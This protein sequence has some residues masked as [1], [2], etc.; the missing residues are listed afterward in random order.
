M[1]TQTW[2]VET[3]AA[4]RYEAL[5]VP[6]LMTAWAPRVV[7]AAGVGTGDRV[8]DVA[9]GTGIVART[10][11]DRVGATGRVVGLD[12][13]PGM[14]AVAARV[15]PDLDWRQG[16]AAALPFPAA[17]F[18][19]VLCQF[20]LMFFPDRLAALREMHRVLTSSGSVALATWA[21]IKVSPPYARQAEIAGRLAGAGAEAIV[22]APFVLHDAA[23]LGGLLDAAGFEAVRVETIR[24]AVTYPSVEAFLEG[25]FDA[26]PLGAMLREL[27]GT[28]YEGAKAEMDEALAPF[29][30]ASGV[31]FPV[32]AHV[33]SGRVGSA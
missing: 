19:R 29:R 4:E 22:R 15:R 21:A 31:T 25:E 8:L 23:E 7:A 28:V 18:E 30:T 26:T 10:A 14:L 32:A 27:G 11:A 12:L 9:C 3:T 13:N 24:D 16:D 5:L 2:Q 1:V 33:V 20:A 17:S 6:A